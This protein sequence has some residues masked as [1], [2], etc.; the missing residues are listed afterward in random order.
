[1][2]GDGD[3]ML[4]PCCVVRRRWLPVSWVTT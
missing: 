2:I 3:V 1:M 4:A